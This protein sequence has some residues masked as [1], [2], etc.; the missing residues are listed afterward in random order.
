MDKG[1]VDAVCLWQTPTT[2]K[3]LMHFLGFSNIFRHFIKKRQ[4]QY[5]TS[6]VS[7]YRQVQVSV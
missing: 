7:P 1:K 5:C 4:F 2:I 6:H 3:E